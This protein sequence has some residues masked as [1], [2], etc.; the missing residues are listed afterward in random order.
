MAKCSLGS[1]YK[2][3]CRCPDCRAYV[4][5]AM[6]KYRR[7][8]A[9]REWGN[10]F[11]TD[12]VS[13]ETACKLIWDAVSV[14]GMSF[15]EVARLCGIDRQT[16]SEIFHQKRDRIL[17]DTEEIIIRNLDKDHVPRAFDGGSLVD[18]H[19]YHH[20]ILGLHAQG[21]R[22][23]DMLAMLRQH[24]FNTGF[25][26]HSKERPLILYRNAKA[27]TWLKEKIGDR[28]GPSRQTAKT[29]EKRGIFP[30]IHYTEDG[31][32]I[33]DSLLPEQRAALRRS[34]RRL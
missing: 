27:I 18:A 1:T 24:G 12:L 9:M 34:Q 2:A 21:W 15:R 30:L 26:R 3:G 29:M 28:R 16:V 23:M 13:P 8:I 17:K 11:P 33:V 14:R 31:Q 25:F 22:E 4:A 19:P 10:S 5:A 32:L 6:K 7:R 20:V